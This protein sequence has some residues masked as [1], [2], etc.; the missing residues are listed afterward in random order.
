MQEPSSFPGGPTD[1]TQSVPFE[2]LDDQGRV[3]DDIECRECGYNLRFADARGSCPECGTAVHW[4]LMGNLLRFA[5]PDWVGNLAKGLKILLITLLVAFIGGLAFGLAQGLNPGRGSFFGIILNVAAGC[6]CG[7][8]YWLLTDPEP[9]QQSDGVNR[10]AVAR[11]CL[12]GSV[13]IG[14]F[15]ALVTGLLSASSSGMNLSGA[16][17]IS[18][19]QFINQLLALVGLACLMFYLRQLA[20]R[21]PHEGLAKQTL[22]VFWGWVIT[23]TVFILAAL[24]IGFFAAAAAS[25]SNTQPTGRFA[26]LMVVGCVGLVAL[27]VFGIWGLILAIRYQ[28]QFAEQT[29]LASAHYDRLTQNPATG[30]LSAF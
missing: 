20:M 15:L 23:L 22:I 17:A 7:W 14:M 16:M 13:L 9:T 2:V 8:G 24:V 3:A 10:R 26:G 30:D 19:V 29:K 18:I 21:I 25:T 12:V 5:D 11:F 1:H 6:F 28:S 4:S 27:L